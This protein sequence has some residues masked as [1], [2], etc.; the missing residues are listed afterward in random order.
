MVAALRAAWGA[1]EAW[2]TS[3]APTHI[4]WACSAIVLING[5][6]CL[7]S[8]YV[9]VADSDDSSDAP[10][11]NR[12]CSGIKGSRQSQ[13]IE[14]RFDFGIKGS[15]QCQTIEMP[16]TGYQ[17]LGKSRLKP[18]SRVAPYSTFDSAGVSHESHPLLGGGAPRKSSWTHRHGAKPL[19][20]DVMWRPWRFFFERIRRVERCSKYKQ[21]PKSQFRGPRFV[22]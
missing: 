19:G 5:S 18:C 13:T 12:T 16:G 15:R 17:L 11:P 21:F 20:D 6:C 9:V 1:A 4:E 8:R 7:C 2:S 10:T 14:M 22:L 3:Y